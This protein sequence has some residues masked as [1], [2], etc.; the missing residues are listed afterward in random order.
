MTFRLFHGIGFVHAGLQ[1]QHIVLDLFSPLSR[2]FVRV[3][4][5]V[6]LVLVQN[7][8]F[9]DREI[10]GLVQNIRRNNDLIADTLDKSIIN[11]EGK[12]NIAACHLVGKR[13]GSLA[14]LVDVVL[15]EIQPFRK[16]VNDSLSCNVV[17][18]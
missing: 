16:T 4:R 18:A 17:T 12:R 10:D 14:K 6:P 15:E 13:I 2:L 1:L 7:I 5:K 8:F 11:I 3:F 9:V